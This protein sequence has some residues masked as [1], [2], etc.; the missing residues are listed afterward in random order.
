LLA[1]NRSLFLANNANASSPSHILFAN[2]VC[3]HPNSRYLPVAFL[4]HCFFDATVRSIFI[5]PRVTGIPYL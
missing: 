4:W 5:F 3:S 1:S 2:R